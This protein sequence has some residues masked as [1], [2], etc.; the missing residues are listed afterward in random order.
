M[1]GPLYAKRWL[2]GWRNIFCLVLQLELQLKGISAQIR[3]SIQEELHIGTSVGNLAKDLG[4][5]IGTI[6]ERNLRIVSGTKQEL[7]EVK[8][9]D[10]ALLINHRIDREELCG[11]TVPCLITLKAVTENPLEMHQVL[12]YV[13]DVNDNSP[14][15]LE[16]NY[17]LEILESVTVGARF[18]VEGAHDPDVGL[19]SLQLFKLNNNIYFRL[20]IED[21]GEDGKV[22]FL[23]LKRPLDREQIA[24]HCLILTAIDGGKQPKSGTLN[25]T[26]I[27]SDVNDNSPV[28]GKQKYT[29][30]MKENAAPGTFLISINA[31]DSD[32]GVNGEI[33][34][35]LRTKFRGLTFQPFDLNSR[36]GELTVKGGLDYEQKQVYEMKV[37]ATDKGA[38][39]L[40]T[41]CN[42]VVKVED[43]DDNPPEID[44]TSMSSQI[45]ENAPPGSVVALRGERTGGLCCA[46]ALTL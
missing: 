19:N 42:V 1:M 5:D 46:H 7:F 9:R 13:I 36:T 31:A 33:E 6:S 14:T 28:C 32:S 39:S 20:E 24:Q 15:F 35:S 23:I 40:S 2:L 43:E 8:Q 34:C 10:G 38:V 37:M 22:P 12:I 25:I 45:P 17:T 26:V 18:Q 21:F 30:T 29:V 4:L 27:V 11:Q 3:Y 41:H 44:I 16:T